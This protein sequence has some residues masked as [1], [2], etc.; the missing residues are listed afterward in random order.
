[1]DTHVVVGSRAGRKAEANCGYP[2]SCGGLWVLVYTTMA[3]GSGHRHTGVGAGNGDRARDVQACSRKDYLQ[4]RTVRQVSDR[5]QG[6]I[7]AH[8]QLQGPGCWHALL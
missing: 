6:L 2:G 7:W 5:R 8:K 3:A 1:M 4:V